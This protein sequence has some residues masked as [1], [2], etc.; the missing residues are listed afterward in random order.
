MRDP[1]I[2]GGYLGSRGFGGN[3]ILENQQLLLY[4]SG[5]VNATKNVLDISRLTR[6]NIVSPAL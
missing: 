2:L 3:E 4:D 1:K 5:I 6:S